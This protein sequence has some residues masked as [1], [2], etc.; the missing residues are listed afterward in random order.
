M[1]RFRNFILNKGIYLIAIGCVAVVCLSG[2][3][4]VNIMDKNKGAPNKTGVSK[5]S[6]A[7]D[8]IALPPERADSS[9]TPAAPS[10]TPSGADTASGAAGPVSTTPAAGANASPAATP[11][12]IKLELPVKG[13]VL[14]D[15]A[16]DKL[17]YNK[18]LDEWRTHSGA[19]IAGDI[20]TAVNAAGGG[21]V[22]DVKNDPR[23]GY[24][25]IVQHTNSVKTVYANLQEKV[26]VKIGDLVK[27]G[28]CIG[29]I[30]KTA[31]FEFAEDPHLHFEVLLND[32]CVNPWDYCAKP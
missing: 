10:N 13:T 24:L 16:M 31:A 9:M 27:T 18:T 20:G 14:V 7:Q 22:I 26:N 1:N 5:T 2:L 28:D 30:G 25:V 11:V 21:K 32:N 8:V 4:V 3:Y 12:P 17:V 15:Y 23:L 6:D 29:W 19:D